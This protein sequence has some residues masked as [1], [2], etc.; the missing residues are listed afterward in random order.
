MGILLALNHLA[1]PLALSLTCAWYQ[2]Y[3]GRGRFRLPSPTGALPRHSPAGRLHS[4]TGHAALADAFELTRALVALETPTGSEG[5]ATDLLEGALRSAGYRTV[6]QPVSP[7]RDNLL[8][9]REPPALVFSTHVDCVPPYVPL[10]RGRRGDPRPGQLRRQGPR[11]RDGGGGRAACRRG[12]SGGSGCC[13]WSAR[14]TAR[15]APASP[16]TWSRAGRFLINGEPTENRLSIGQKGS[17][18]VDLQRHRARRALRLSRRGRERHRGAARHHRADPPDAP[19]APTRCSGASTLNVGLIRAASRPNVLPP[20]G[21]RA[22]PD[23]DGR[24]DRPAQ[25]RASRRWPRR[26]SP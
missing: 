22:D 7:G 11:R 13:S 3:S 2:W 24:A 6:R 16:P 10:V 20:D 15:T 26:A 19:A 9:F 4:W 25:G 14:R 1:A 12:A 17:L 23:P 8:A 5:P 21:Q 18:R